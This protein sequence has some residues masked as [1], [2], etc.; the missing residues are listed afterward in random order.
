MP[1][2]YSNIRIPRLGHFAN[3]HVSEKFPS[4]LR[5][6][7]YGPG[8]SYVGIYLDVNPPDNR[9]HLK[10]RVVD[11]F[12]SANTQGLTDGGIAG[13][14]WSF[15]WTFLGFGIVMLSLAEMASMYVL[16]HHLQTETLLDM[17]TNLTGRLSQEANTTGSPNLPQPNTRNSSV[18]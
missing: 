15:V 7:F 13:L 12:V 2:S 1:A 18:T 3:W 14:F 17:L 16:L 5:D 10:V 9:F 6:E 8:P 11:D 4:S